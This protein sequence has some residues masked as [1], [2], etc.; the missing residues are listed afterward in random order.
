MNTVIPTDSALVTTLG[1]NS[2]AW[3]THITSLYIPANITTLQTGFNKIENYHKLVITVDAGNSIYKS[4]DKCVIN[5]Q[6]KELVHYT[7]GGT[8]PAD[9]SVTKLAQHSIEC[10]DNLYINKYITYIDPMA[11]RPKNITCDTQNSVFRVE[12]NCL[13]EK[14]SLKIVRAGINASIPSD[15][16]SIGKY[17]FLDIKNSTIQTLIIPST[18]TKI[19]SYVFYYWNYGGSTSNIVIYL[20]KSVTTIEENAFRRVSATIY[21]DATSTSKPSGW[22]S[23][24]CSGGADINWK[25]GYTLEQFKS[26]N[27]L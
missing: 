8:I 26:E 6:T 18:C 14:S 17:A 2:F 19:E 25:Y 13:I 27:G 1:L 22:N 24:M 7:N 4:I 15:I 16:K 20:P 23:N 21:T 5:K 3:N 11:I 10:I 9:G 12:G